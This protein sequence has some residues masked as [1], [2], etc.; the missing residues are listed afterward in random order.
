MLNEIKIKL[1]ACSSVEQIREYKNYVLNIMD[2][3]H[4]EKMN[5]LD[6]MKIRHD[7]ELDEIGK[8]I[9]DA[10]ASKDFSLVQELIKK[11]TEIMKKQNDEMLSIM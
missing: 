2:R 5:R 1:D 4:V 10:I 11:Q 3:E 7:A 6:E 9:K 8:K